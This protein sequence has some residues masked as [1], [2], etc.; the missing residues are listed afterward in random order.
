VKVVYNPDTESLGPGGFDFC[1][2][3][4]YGSI[5]MCMTEA[6]QKAGEADPVFFLDIGCVDF[7]I[8][9]LPGETMLGTHGRTPALAAGFKYVEPDRLV[10]AIQGDGGFMSVGAG[11]SLHSALRGD[12]ITVVVLNNG[13]LADTGGQFSPSTPPSITTTT[14]PNGSGRRPLPFLEM[15]ASLDGVAYAQRVAVDSVVGVRRVTRAISR[16]LEVQRQAKGIGIVEIL[17]PC[18]THWRLD[19]VES[20][21]MIRSELTVH[22]PLGVLK[23]TPGPEQSHE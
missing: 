14:S 22:Y 10:I 6:L 21:E 15:L 3:C 9:H 23:P 16:A 7:M 5:V 18:P 19:S 20:W 2:G 1:P 12:P 4:G 13:V 11:E 8:G 17:S